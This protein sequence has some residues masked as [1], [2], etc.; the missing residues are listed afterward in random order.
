[1]SEVMFAIIEKAATFAMA[2]PVAATV[3]AVAAIGAYAAIEIS[4]KC[5]DDRK[6]EDRNVG[7]RNGRIR[8]S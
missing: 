2:N 4:N 5:S 1:M 3:I 8:Q 6:D 7:N